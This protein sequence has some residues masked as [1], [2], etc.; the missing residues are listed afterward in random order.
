NIGGILASVFAASNF[1]GFLQ[2][3]ADATGRFN[4]FLQTAEGT[5]AIRNIFQGLGDIATALVPVV[6]ALATSFGNLAPP[7]GRIA[8]AMSPVLATAMVTFSDALSRLEPGITAVI[9]GLADGIDRIAGSGALQAL[10]EGL[11]AVFEAIAPA[12]PTIGAL[13]SVVGHTLAAALQVAA[14]IL[15]LLAQAIGA[16]GAVIPQNETALR[17]LGATITGL[18][19]TIA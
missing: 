18:A 11:S 8:Q 1:Q 15:G 12:I 13:A 6:E 3:I 19:T 5:Q 2:S 10:G 4:A 9:H 17:I 7:I 16:V 14:P